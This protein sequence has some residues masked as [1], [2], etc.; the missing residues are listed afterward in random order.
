MFRAVGE[1]LQG[2][3]ADPLPH[4]VEV[5]RRVRPRF[6]VMRGREFLMKDAYSFDLDEAPARCSYQQDDAG[7]YAHLPAH[8]PEGDPDG[9]RERA[10]RRRPQPRVHHPGQTGESAVFSTVGMLDLPF[11]ARTSTMPAISSRS[12]RTGPASTPP[13]RMCTTRRATSAR[14]RGRPIDGARHRGRPDLLLR[15][16][17]FQADEGDVTGPDGA[18]T[19]GADGQLRRRRLAPGRRDHRGQ[20]RRGRHHLAGQPSRRSASAS[21]TC[22]RRRRRSTPPARAP[23]R[24]LTARRQGAAATT[25]PTSAPAASSRPWT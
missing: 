5:P 12:S 11:P 20:P 25:T 15:R 3:A 19:A 2:A 22:A 10:D 21:S 1:E 8:G 7:L 13:P 14:P 6:G 17:V 16:Q 24:R 23:T 9:G 4:P 18:E